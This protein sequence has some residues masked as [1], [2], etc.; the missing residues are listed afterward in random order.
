MLAVL[1]QLVR[2]HQDVVAGR[3]RPPASSEAPVL[4]LSGRTVGVVGLGNIGKKVARRARGFEAR[5]QLMRSGGRQP[6]CGQL[7]ER[8]QFAGVGAE[9]R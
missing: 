6:R 3:W 5:V 4:E 9:D 7:P 8:R 2:F 1:K